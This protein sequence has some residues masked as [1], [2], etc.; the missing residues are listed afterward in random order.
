MS[1][2]AKIEKMKVGQLL[3]AIISDE[4]GTYKNAYLWIGNERGE[5]VA[6]FDTLKQLEKLKGWCE[7]ILAA[8]KG[9][10]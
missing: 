4:E 10:Y 8:N 7:K 3:F 1:D 5:Y 9:K 2:K 6:D